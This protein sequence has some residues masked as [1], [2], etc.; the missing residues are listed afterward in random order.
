VASPSIWCLGRPRLLWPA[1]APAADA[2][3]ARQALIAHELAHLARRDHWVSWLEI[4]A[5]ALAWWNPLFWWIRGR[6]R[7]FAEL[8]CDAWAV[9]TYPADRR[10]FAEALIELQ[11]RTRAAP[12][13]LQGLGATDSE[14]K[15]F[16]RRLDMI[17]K[18]RTFPGISKGLAACVAALAVLSS[19]GFSRGEECGGKAS[20]CSAVVEARSKSQKLAKQAGT[21]LNQ[22]EDEQA[23]A[24]LDEVV[25]L[26]PKNAWAHGQLGHLR[27]RAGH[28]DAAR[29]SFERQ[30]QLG[31]DRADA[32][33]NAACATARGG[34]PAGALE[35]VAAA[36][37]HGFT[38]A[39]LMESDKDLAT[40]RGD[41]RFQEL[42]AKVRTAGELRAELAR[43]EG[44]QPALFL[45]AHAELASIWIG[46]GN[47]QSEH[48][49]LALKAGDLEGAAVA[50]GRQAAAGFDA[51]RAFY[52]RACARSLAGDLAG[53]MADLELAADQG[54]GFEG[55]G[56]DTDLDRLREQ[57]GFA[58]VEKRILAQ[59]EGMKGIKALLASRDPKDALALT[60]LVADESQPEKVR[61]LASQTLGNLQLDEGRFTEA[62]TSFTRAAELGLEPR[63]PAFGLARALAGGGRK[64]EARHH[65]AMAVDLGFDDP[66]ALKTLLEAHA[67]AAPEEAAEWVARATE[68]RTKGK[69]KDAYGAKGKAWAAGLKPV[70]T[71]AGTTVAKE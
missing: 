14:C 64:P 18:K 49:H 60:K 61:S 70:K 24:L 69:G 31:Y 29:Q 42:V 26:D 71:A 67:L 6:I 8:S 22:R 43:L 57:P 4:P 41:E 21:L 54:M 11:A 50:F 15:D 59:A 46:D 68:F 12:V 58:D 35:R 52:N 32:L 48:G 27:I 38:D 36:V 23:L 51:P 45:A 16:E 19:P 20:T 56:S 47:L 17:M 30:Y 3:R 66:D 40:I 34:D 62:Q 53:A 13:A 63:L 5:A 28:F 33:Y 10:P 39:A 2:P 37:A 25:S 1:F 44:S 9:W 55:I 7:H 65:V